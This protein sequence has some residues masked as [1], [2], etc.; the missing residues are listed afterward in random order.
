MPEAIAWVYFQGKNFSIQ[1]RKSKI[2]LSRL[3]QG[4]S[5]KRP[6]RLL[7]VEIYLANG[8]ISAKSYWPPTPP[9]PLER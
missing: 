5:K 3:S 8:M 6:D 7:K 9:N 1:N 2:A 4:K